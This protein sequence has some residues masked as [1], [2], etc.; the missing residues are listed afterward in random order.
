MNQPCS[1]E[2]INELVIL[3]LDAIAVV[4]M[5]CDEAQKVAGFVQNCGVGVVATCGDSAGGGTIG[6]I[7]EGLA[8]FRVFPG[9]CVDEPAETVAVNVD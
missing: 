9:G 6:S 3:G 8:E 4:A 1:Q 2:G 5:A 7:C